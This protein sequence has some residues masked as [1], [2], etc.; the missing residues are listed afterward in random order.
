MISQLLLPKL[1]EWRPTGQGRHSWSHYLQDHG[2]N[3]FLTADKVDS[4]GSLV[5]ELSVARTVLL[6]TE[7]EEL[8]DWAARVAKRATGL[9]EPLRVI[10]ID[11]TRCEAI[12][13]SESPASRGESVFYYEVKLLGKNRAELRRFEAK[14][15]LSGRREQVA[16]ALTHEAIAKLLGDLIGSSKT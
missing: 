8:S 2:W 14:P 4:L 5:W 7:S 1:S 15:G 12:L 6:D 11:S 3:A 9:M 13:R 10:E 16:F